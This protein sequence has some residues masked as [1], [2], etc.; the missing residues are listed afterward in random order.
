VAG[1]KAPAGSV[2]APHT[3]GTVTVEFK[4]GAR[5]ARKLVD[6][7]LDTDCRNRPQAVVRL[8][9]NVVAAVEVEELNTS[10]GEASSSEGLYSRRLRITC[11]SDI[12][13]DSLLP[14]A[15][16]ASKPLRCVSVSPDTNTREYGKIMESSCE[17]EFSLDR[18]ELQSRNSDDVG[19]FISG[20]VVLQWKN[21]NQVKQQLGWE[22][23]KYKKISPPSLL[24]SKSAQSSD[25]ETEVVLEHFGCPFRIK[26]VSG[27]LVD[28]GFLLAKFDPRRIEKVH[29]ISLRIKPNQVN[30][31][32]VSRIKVVTDQR[33]LT[34]D[35][36][37]LIGP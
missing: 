11:R 37:V 33:F 26:A 29:T 31:N 4:P 36:L 9:A 19:T 3:G 24:L 2:L 5:T 15:V 34:F 23:T 20:E 1:S 16:L 21:G 8:G 12:S 35:V 17:Y 10:R 14:D 22:L 30:E 18:G 28:R 6:L 27:G 32:G 25:F 13:R 7:V